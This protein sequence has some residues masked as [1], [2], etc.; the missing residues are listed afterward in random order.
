MHIYMINNKYIA[1]VLVTQKLICRVNRLIFTSRFSSEIQIC[2][3][4]ALSLAV[5]AVFTEVCMDRTYR[6]ALGT[7]QNGILE[8]RN[9]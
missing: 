3:A 6:F 1:N 9:S 5:L 7:R 4:Q 8:V 2:L